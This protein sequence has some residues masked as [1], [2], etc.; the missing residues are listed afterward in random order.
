MIE[1]FRIG[2]VSRDRTLWEGVDLAAGPGEM[3][4]VAGPPACG[5]T[6]LMQVL[7]GE[8]RPDAGDV[9]VDGESLFRG[10]PEHNRRFRASS[11]VVPESFPAEP[12]K[13]L[14]ELFLLSSLALGG[15]TDKERKGRTA[16]LLALVGLPGA[17]NVE[18]SF[19]SSSERARAALAVELFRSPRYLFLDMLLANAGREWTDRMGALLRALAREEKTILMMERRLPDE[20]Q[21]QKAPS[22]LS[23]G[24]FT[25]YRVGAAPRASK[26]KG[27][28][29]Q[30]QSS[31]VS[32]TAEG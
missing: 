5:K 21:A 8:R 13:T 31:P 1:A 18:V 23:A 30:S 20:W 15:L 12:G 28:E 22:P 3:L 9:V 17:E 26:E 29:R 2:A 32:G 7:R 6:L 14:E 10:S 16:D 27:R 24:P 11:G 4:V 25:L 19:L